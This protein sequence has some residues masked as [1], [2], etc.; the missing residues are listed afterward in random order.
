MKIIVEEGEEFA[1]LTAGTYEIHMTQLDVS[2]ERDTFAH[3]RVGPARTH[4]EIQGQL[5]GVGCATCGELAGR[6]D[7][8][9]PL[10]IAKAWAAANNSTPAN[11]S[12]CDNLNGP[13]S[14]GAWHK[15]RGLVQRAIS[16]VVPADCDR[17]DCRVCDALRKPRVPMVVG[18][19]VGKKLRE[20]GNLPAGAVVVPMNCD[21]CQGTGEWENPANGKRSPCSRGCGRPK[22]VAVSS[23]GIVRNVVYTQP[24]KWE[25]PQGSGDLPS[26]NR[27]PH[28]FRET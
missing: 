10:G 2:Y 27:R 11:S 5:V 19:A 4:V 20:T 1:G 8:Q 12:Q 23:E 25:F 16:D 24:C 26:C 22:A 17:A 3:H 7:A 18:E 21:E 14:C 13:C 28:Y 9:C 6:H 15:P